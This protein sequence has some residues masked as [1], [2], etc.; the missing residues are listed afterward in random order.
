[1]HPLARTRTHCRAHT[2][3]STT[4]PRT[5]GDGGATRGAAPT[6]RGDA[7]GGKNKCETDRAHHMGDG[8]EHPRAH[9]ARARPSGH[10]ALPLGKFFL[11]GFAQAIG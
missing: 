2:H 9:K 7:T 3:I 10:T 4:R 8:G 11:P 1:M 5:I 6:S